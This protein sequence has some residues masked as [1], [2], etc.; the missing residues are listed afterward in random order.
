MTLA[1]G[2]I[3]RQVGVFE[4][5][6]E[7]LAIGWIDGNADARGHH[8]FVP[9]EQYWSHD[10]GQNA[11]RDNRGLVWSIDT[12]HQEHEL[13]ASQPRKIPIAGTRGYRSFHL[14]AA[15]HRLAQAQCRHA[16]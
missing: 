9:C 15:A 11:G 1:F 2:K 4:Q 14:V 7:V 12:R 16:Q 13:V 6:F 3:H 5:R 10:R 8:N